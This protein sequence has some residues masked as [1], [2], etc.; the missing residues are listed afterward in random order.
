MNV[1][2]KKNGKT[3]LVGRQ[4]IFRIVAFEVKVKDYVRYQ[5]IKNLK[6]FLEEYSDIVKAGVLI[7]NGSEIKRVDKKIIALPWTSLL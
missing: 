3:S 2:H 6:I 4:Q 1:I 5:D 7:Y